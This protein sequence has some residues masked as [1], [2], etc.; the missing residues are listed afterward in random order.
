MPQFVRE[1]V[2]PTINDIYF[3]VKNRL[4]SHSYS[5]VSK[6]TDGGVLEE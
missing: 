6:T 2:S 5:M 3:T 1:K 4:C